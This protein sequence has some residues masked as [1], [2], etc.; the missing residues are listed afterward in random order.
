MAILPN[1]AFLQLIA[2]GWVVDNVSGGCSGPL[3]DNTIMLLLTDATYDAN[4]H[5]TDLTAQEANFTGYSREAV[6]YQGPYA[7]ADGSYGVLS[8]ENQFTPAADITASNTIWGYAVYQ[9]GDTP[10]VMFQEQFTEGAV[11]GSPLNFL[12]IAVDVQVSADGVYGTAEVD[13]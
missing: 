6:T 4:V 9:G 7:F 5:L 11:I 3:V 8:L 12:N 1:N 2:Q 10:M 13:N